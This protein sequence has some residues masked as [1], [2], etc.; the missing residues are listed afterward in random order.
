MGCLGGYLT[1]QGCYILVGTPLSYQRVGSPFIVANLWI[2]L[3]SEVCLF[4][5]ILFREILKDLE[6]SSERD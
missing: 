5:K 2:M 3:E 6:L 4:V 1:L